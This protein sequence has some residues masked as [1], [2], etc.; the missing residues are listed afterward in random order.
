[1][2]VV[3]SRLHPTPGFLS[4]GDGNGRVCIPCPPCVD[5]ADPDPGGRAVAHSSTEW[6]SGTV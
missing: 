2:S 5:P 4:S 6:P 3:G 1:M